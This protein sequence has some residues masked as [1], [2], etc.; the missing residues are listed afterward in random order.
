MVTY[1]VHTIIWTYVHTD[2]QASICFHYCK[3]NIISNYLN[4]CI[5]ILYLGP[6]SY[7]KPTLKALVI[8]YWSEDK[9]LN[10]LA[11]SHDNVFIFSS[12]DDKGHS[13]L[14]KEIIRTITIEGQTVLDCSPETGTIIHRRWNRGGRGALAPPNLKVQIVNTCSNQWCQL[15]VAVKSQLIDF[16]APCSVLDSSLPRALQRLPIPAQIEK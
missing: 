9:K 15:W 7:L 14:K 12:D 1:S 6:N 2:K 13:D 8:G 10:K 16:E 3:N 11:C 5:I 4:N